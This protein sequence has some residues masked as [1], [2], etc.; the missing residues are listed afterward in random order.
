MWEKW[1]KGGAGGVVKSLH[2][3]VRPLPAYTLSPFT[4][5]ERKHNLTIFK[6]GFESW[7][8]KA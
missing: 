3:G 7:S 8:P 2:Q 4:I 1:G 6:N 5:T